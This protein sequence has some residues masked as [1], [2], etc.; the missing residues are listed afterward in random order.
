M[1]LKHYWNGDQRGTAGNYT[2][3]AGRKEDDD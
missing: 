3:C 2:N 1:K